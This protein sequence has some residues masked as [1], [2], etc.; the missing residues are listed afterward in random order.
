VDACAGSVGRWNA[1][2]LDAS[3]RPRITYE[4]N[5][6]L[7]HAERNGATW[8][9]DVV[10][11]AEETGAWSSLAI[12]DAG[13]SRIA[14]FDAT[15]G[16]LR[17][18]I[19]QLDVTP[20]AAP[21][22]SAEAGRTTAVVSWSGS[23]DDG[24]SGVAWT[25]IVRMSSQPIHDANFADGTLVPTSGS[26][27]SVEGL[28]SCSPYYFAV[29]ALD[30][31]GNAS[32]VTSVMVATSCDGSLEILCEGPP[33]KPAFDLARATVARSGSVG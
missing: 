26:C 7:S 8:A 18:A 33:A 3:D 13:N 11:A 22:V 31:L 10:D 12:D 32:P 16:N 9:I 2:A 20:P 23:G 21:Q 1:I 5:G 19:S 17:Y 24:T 29:M 30:D 14:Y 4:A 25:Y 28:N 27:A 15:N 6:L